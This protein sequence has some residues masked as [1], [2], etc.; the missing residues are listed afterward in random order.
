MKHLIL[1]ILVAILVLSE[2]C[3]ARGRGGGSRGGRG[4]SRSGSRGSRSRSS[5]G[6]SS[7]PRITKTTPIAA[8]SRTTAVIRNQ[9]KPGYR[10]NTGRNLLMGYLL[11]S[12]TFRTA[13]VYRSQYQLYGRRTVR[14][15]E[16]RAIRIISTETRL[17]DDDNK[18]CLSEA[19]ATVARNLSMDVHVVSENAT[20]RYN[21]ESPQPFDGIDANFTL[22]EKEGV[23]FEIVTQTEYNG[24]VVEGENC[25]VVQEKVEGTV[26]H[27]YAT[28]P[29]GATALGASAFLSI[30]ALLFALLW[31]GHRA[32]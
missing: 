4:S 23:N 28:N 27:M 11:Y 5:G 18:A 9:A 12:Y 20:I 1:V 2:V 32:V 14:I 15:P 21:D 3:D 8:K 7:K 26:V 25:F 31:P 24:T 30:L 29:D 17:L 16:E 19:E 22:R 10:S 6:S 13:P